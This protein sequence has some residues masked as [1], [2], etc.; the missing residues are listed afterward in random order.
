MEAL[1]INGWQLIVQLIAFLIFIVLLWKYALGPIVGVIDARQDRIR[2]SMEAAERM[3][4]EL[5]ATQARNE[6]VLQEAR[7]EGQEIIANARQNSEQMIARAREEADT[8][9][10]TYLKRAEETLRRETEQA[11]QQLRQDV[12]DLAVAA[13]G[14]IVRKELDPSTQSRLIEETLASASSGRGDGIARQ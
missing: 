11:R 1:G 5:K 7:R 10:D 9:A 14:R 3:Q 6:E 4:R 2:E 12:A 13:A 8:Q